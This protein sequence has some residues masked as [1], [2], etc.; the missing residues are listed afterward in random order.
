MKI[1]HWKEI[2]VQ[3]DLSL[4]NAMN[5]MNELGSKILFI[6]D[7]DFRLLGSL[8]DGDIRRGLIK[9]FDIEIKAYELSKK[10]PIFV[11]EEN[12]PNID[13]LDNYSS[14]NVVPILKEEKIVDI[15][16]FENNN[17]ELK[18]SVLVQAGGFGKRLSPLTDEIPKPMLK[19]GNMPIL[20]I[21]I[22][23]FKKNGFYNFFISTHYR[24]EKIK[25]FFGNGEKHNVR[26]N[27]IDEAY[28]L[29][30]AG[31]LSLIPLE[32]IKFPLIVI[33]G[34]VLTKLDFRDLIN[35]HKKRKSKITA[36]VRKFDY[37]IPFGVF[38]G[39]EDKIIGIS[40]KPISSF[41][42]NAGIYV[43]EKSV[44]ENLSFNKK[45]DFPSLISNQIENNENS[46][47]MYLIHEYWKDIGKKED[48]E[49]AQQ[50]I[51]TFN[52]D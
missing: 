6:V 36:C 52:F 28:P 50:D 3:K 35:F 41:L 5:V 29:G 7:S 30:T 15:Y 9:N 2:C 22:K 13:N 37:Q 23:Q 12:K 4:K 45:I 27:Y 20:E 17:L 32:Q 21:I 44:V 14:I 25:D 18:N 26:I 10:N 48:F 49:K 34:D 39:D 40:E 1:K 46:V 31:A 47:S 43:I 24:P 8:S 16:F 33:N 38:R 19:V 42:I 51:L 11:T